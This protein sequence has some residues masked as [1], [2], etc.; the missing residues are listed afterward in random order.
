MGLFFI[1]LGRSM[2]GFGLQDWGLEALGLR[3]LVLGLGGVGF[4]IWG[5]GSRM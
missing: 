1:V 3:V 5:A 4:L 2:R